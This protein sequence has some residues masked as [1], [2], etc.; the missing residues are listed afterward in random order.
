MGSINDNVNFKVQRL[1]SITDIAKEVENV[2]ADLST[3]SIFT[4]KGRIMPIKVYDVSPAAANILKQEMLSLGGDAIVHRNA[5]NCKIEKSDVL[6]LG[7]PR[8]YRYLKDKLAYMP[9]WGLKEIG[10]LIVSIMKK[11]KTPPPMQTSHGTLSFDKPLIMGIINATPDSF[12]EHSRKKTIEDVVKTARRMI[13]EGA[14]ILDIGGESTRPGADPVP[15]EEEIKRVIPAIKAIRD[16]VSNDIIISV[17]TYKAEVAEKALAAGADIINDISGLRFDK[18]MAK[19][20]RDFGVPVVIMHIKG[21]PRN[22][23]KN[24]HYDNFMKELHQYFMER[25]EYATS[26]GIDERNIILDPGIGFGKR[27]QDNVDIFNQIEGMLMY[28]RPILIGASRKSMIGMILDNI[29]PTERLEGTLAL[30]ALAVDRGAHI[31]RVH[32]VKENRKV[33]DLTYYLKAHR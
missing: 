3:I 17:D 19:I 30:T 29:P 2:G 8:H 18:N 16:E 4:A 21:T 14:D 11:D 20:A 15:V 33:A 32:D 5:I 10:E 27:L 1:S 13:E 23:Q 25:I 26:E 28:G 7:T 22:M 24:P 31:I 9:Y 12:F 6:L